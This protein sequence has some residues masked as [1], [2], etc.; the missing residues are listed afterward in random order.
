VHVSPFALLPAGNTI[1]DYPVDRNRKTAGRAAQKVGRHEGGGGSLAACW[2]RE[3]RQRENARQ[4]AQLAVAHDTI[5][6]PTT[7][8]Y[9]Y[10]STSRVQEEPPESD[11]QR[12]AASRQ[13]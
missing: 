5:S 11:Q 6:E 7:Y 3:Q 4:Q 10:Y 8:W 9:G 13:R 1:T 12:P 2:L